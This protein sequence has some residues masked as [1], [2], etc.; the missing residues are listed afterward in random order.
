MK[1]S[2]AYEQTRLEHIIARARKVGR[3]IALE[4]RLPLC[5][6]FDESLA[7]D[8]ARMQVRRR[9]RREMP[10]ATREELTWAIEEELTP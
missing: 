5:V 10:D 1:P 4:R 6:A 9:L 7:G 2:A 8:V 3:A